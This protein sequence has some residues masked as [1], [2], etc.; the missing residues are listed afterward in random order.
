MGFLPFTPRA[1]STVFGLL[2]AFFQDYPLTHWLPRPLPLFSSCLLHH[3]PS[4]DKIPFYLFLLYT[5][6]SL[7]SSMACI[8]WS[9]LFYYFFW[10]RY[11]PSK[12][13]FPKEVTAGNQIQTPLFPPTT[14]P[15]PLNPLD[16]GPTSLVLAGYRLVVPRPFCACS[17]L[18]SVFVSHAISAVADQLCF[19]LLRVLSYFFTC[20]L[21][22]LSFSF[23]LA[24]LSFT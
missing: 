1:S 6:T 17:P 20:F 7:P 2:W 4:H 15:R 8:R 19:G 13:S 21:L 23:G 5:S 12:I 9:Q 18:S 22:F 10:V 14:K 3:Y 16:R 24:F 11:H